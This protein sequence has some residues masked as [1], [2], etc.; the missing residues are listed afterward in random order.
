VV[1]NAESDYGSAG[2]YGWVMDLNFL[3]RGAVSLAVVRA[4]MLVGGVRS[5]RLSVAQAG[6]TVWALASAALAFFP[7]NASAARR[8]GSAGCTWRWRSSPS[9]P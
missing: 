9:P 4:L 7:D 1:H 3:L 8:T 6:L 5:R 2:P